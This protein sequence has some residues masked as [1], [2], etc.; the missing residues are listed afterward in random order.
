MEEVKALEGEGQG[1]QLVLSENQAVYQYDTVDSSQ[2]IS[3]YNRLHKR[4]SF[5]QTWI[6]DVSPVEAL[7]TRCLTPVTVIAEM[8]CLLP[9]SMKE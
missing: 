7:V 4:T 8:Q 6:V 2:I 1:Q 5:S 3:Y 9:L